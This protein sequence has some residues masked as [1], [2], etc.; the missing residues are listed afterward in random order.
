MFSSFNTINRIVYGFGCLDDLAGEIKR[1]HGSK[2]LVITDP[3]VK[4]A[5]LLEPVTKILDRARLPFQVFAEVEA[6][7]SI[8]VVIKSVEAAKA[9]QPDMIVGI[10]GG[11]SLDISKATSIL[12]TNPGSIYDYLG[13]DLVPGP[14]VP[15]ILIPTT[16]GTGS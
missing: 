16:S 15:T 5:G 7:P 14:G 11:S 13:M 2:I 6:D 3:G 12:L 1:L 10:G 9:F 8:D 4:A